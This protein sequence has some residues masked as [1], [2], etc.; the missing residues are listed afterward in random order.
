MYVLCN[1]EILC[2]IYN[3]VLTIIIYHIQTLGKIDKQRLCE[4]L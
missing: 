1:T 2:I 3:Y 4:E